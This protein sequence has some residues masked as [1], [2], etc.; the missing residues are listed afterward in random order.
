MILFGM[1]VYFLLPNQTLTLVSTKAVGVM[2]QLEQTQVFP[3]MHT[4]MMNYQTTYSPTIDKGSETLMNLFQL[5]DVAIA[6]AQKTN[7]TM[8]VQTLLTIL[9]ESNTVLDA[10]MTFFAP[11][12]HRVPPS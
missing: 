12:L 5:L 11:F 7:M 8:A 9:R 2:S 3:T 6:E 10:V 1:L 4:M